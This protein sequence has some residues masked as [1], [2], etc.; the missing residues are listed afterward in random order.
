MD[1]YSQ[2]H[3]QGVLFLDQNNYQQALLTLN[4]A[5]Q[6]A[7]QAQDDVARATILLSLARLHYTIYNFY[8][9]ALQVHNAIELLRNESAPDLIAQAQTL[10]GF[11]Y[12]E[13]GKWEEAEIFLHLTDQYYSN[14]GI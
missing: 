9:A 12:T 6:G 3:E 8:H 1:P 2:L 11:I 4:Q 14:N 7:A 5:V 10:L 13:N